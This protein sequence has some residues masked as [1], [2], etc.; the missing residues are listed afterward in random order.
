MRVLNVSRLVQNE[1]KPAPPVWHEL[2]HEILEVFVV[3]SF[4]DVDHLVDYYVLEALG[5]FLG[6]FEV[7]PD[8]LYFGVAAVGGNQEPSRGSSSGGA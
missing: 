7:E 4:G 1:T 6:E 2:V 3:E 5:T 8:S